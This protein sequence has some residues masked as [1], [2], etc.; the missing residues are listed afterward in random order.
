MENAES[1]CGDNAQTVTQ[2][3]GGA[4]RGK[5]GQDASIEKVLSDL[6]G[7]MSVFSKATK[8]IKTLAQAVSTLREDVNTLKRKSPDESVAHTTAKK[9]RPS[10]S[11][12][13]YLHNIA[14]PPNPDGSVSPESES[15]DTD[16][17]LEA[18][19][20]PPGSDQTQHCDDF[21]ELEEFF[22]TDEGTGEEMSARIVKISE[23]ALKGAR[24]KK[25]D[26]KLQALKEKH[27]RPKNV[28]L[29]QV[30]KVDEGLWRQLKREVKTVD[31]LQQKAIGTYGQALVPIMKAME[32]LQGVKEQQGAMRHVMDAFKILSLSIKVTN[33]NRTDRIKKE[34]QPKFR[35]LCQNEASA[36]NLLGDNFLEAVKKLEGTKGNLTLS[37]QPFLGKR[38]G[39]KGKQSSHRHNQTYG[40]GYRQ[41]HKKF[42]NSNNN[43]NQPHK[44]YTQFKKR[45][46]QGNKK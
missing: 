5:S 40:H 23:K 46:Q 2:P 11:N 20:N 8:D 45:N 37:T 31:Y 26:E 16:D 18:F 15:D 17:E 44:N 38:G 3:N 33:A 24:N 19:M 30:P 28:P 6:A 4:E 36:T 22:Q 7:R 1:Q 42:N 21:E 12:D 10:T 32:C 9:A 34:L 29:L 43:Y 39:D 25:V 27:L 41:G 35:A 14:S 13:D